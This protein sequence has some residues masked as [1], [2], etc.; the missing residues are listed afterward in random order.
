ME[1]WLFRLDMAN[2]DTR[3]PVNLYKTI[4]RVLYNSMVHDFNL[5]HDFQFFYEL[6]PQIQKM[7][8]F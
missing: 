5:I 8:M 4:H 1:Y 7:V 6:P 3:I 2:K